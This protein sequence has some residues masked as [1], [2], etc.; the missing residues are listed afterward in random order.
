MADSGGQF[1]T[2]ASEFVLVTAGVGWLGS[3]RPLYLLELV[4]GVTSW[5]HG[6]MRSQITEM[7]L[8]QKKLQRPQQ[9]GCP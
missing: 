3:L 9:K 8:K 4:S 7:R 1:S 5:A 2:S 6:P